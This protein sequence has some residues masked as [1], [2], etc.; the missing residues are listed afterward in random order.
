M[1]LQ[2]IKKMSKKEAFNFFNKLKPFLTLTQNEIAREA[3]VSQGTVGFVL[4]GL[5]HN[6]KVI[7][8]IF[9]NLN[10]GWEEAV[11]ESEKIPA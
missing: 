6:E 9:N 8:V 11:F 10:E 5:T 4:G 7:E 2:S 3:N 1:N